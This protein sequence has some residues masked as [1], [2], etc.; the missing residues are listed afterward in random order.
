MNKKE[1]FE[2]HDNFCKKLR[3]ITAAKNADYTGGS[4]NPFENF[5][6]VERDSIASTEAGFL[7][8]MR[9]KF[10]RIISFVNQGT[11]QV[12]DESVQDTLLDLANYCILMSAYIESKKREKGGFTI[13]KEQLQETH[14]KLQKISSVYTNHQQTNQ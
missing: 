5:C 3:E 7:V 10:S 14:D 9:D 11:L 2:Y 4:S 6:S 8:R 12:K 1:W 13:S